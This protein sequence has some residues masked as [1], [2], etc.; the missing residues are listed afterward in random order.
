[1]QII[2]F[3]IGCLLIAVNAQFFGGINRFPNGGQSE[4]FGYKAGPVWGSLSQDRNRLGAT[5]PK[6]IGG[7]LDLLTPRGSGLSGSILHQPGIG[8]QASIRGQA[9]IL[10]TKN[11][12]LNAWAQHDRFLNKNF[13]LVGPETNSAGLNFDHKNGFNAFGSVS[14]TNGQRTINTVGAGLPLFKSNDGNTKLSVQGSSSF[15]SGSK[16]NHNIGLQFQKS[17]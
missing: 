17:F 3:L 12:D 6:T 8:G 7:G 14:K 5:G 1:M 13:K 4:S 2:F 10:H 16:P 11:S 9:N 15:Q